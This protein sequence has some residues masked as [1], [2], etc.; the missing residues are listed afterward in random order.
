MTHSEASPF[1]DGRLKPSVERLWLKFYPDHEAQAFERKVASMVR[2]D[3]RVLEVGAGSG[4]G[5][6]KVFPLKGRCALYAGVD[7]DPRVLGNP[8]L[9][10]AYVADAAHLPFKEAEF[11]LVFHKMVA[12]HLENPGR[13]LA[14]IARV[15]KPDGH[16]LF[17]TPSRF[18]YAMLIANWTP[19]WFHR[20]FVRRFGSGRSDGEVFPTYYRLNDKPTIEQLCREAKLDAAVIFQSIPP[21]YLRSNAVTFLIG[22]LY[23]RTAERFFP[24]LRARLWVFARKSASPS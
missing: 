24:P 21:G 13:A 5:L 10:K 23:E 14:E 11:D 22:I 2:P 17:E 9:D 18:Y 15:L 12:E 20:F 7:L 1:A 4:V 3:M 19:T 16:L 8:N 6:Q